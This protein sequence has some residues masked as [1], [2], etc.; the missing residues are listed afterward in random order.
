MRGADKNKLAVDLKRYAK[1][2]KIPGGLL[3][4]C[5]VLEG[6]MLNKDVTHAQMRRYIKNPR[7]LLLDC[8]LEYKKGESATNMEMSEAN[9]MV[10]ALQQEVN[11]VAQM[12]N[13]IMK[14]TPD[15]VVTEKGVSDLAQHF[16]MK[17]NISVIR[18]ARKTDN[19][20]ISRVTGATICNR[21]EELQESDIGTLCGLYEVK[22][23]GDDFFSYFVDCKEPKACTILLRG[24]SKDT[25]NELER[26]LHDAMA[27]AKNVVNSPVLLPGGGAIEMEVAQRLVDFSKTQEG[28]HQLPIKAVARAMEIIPRTLAQNCGGDT[29]RL[30]T[31]LRA[32]H[33]LGDGLYYGIDGNKG[34][35]YI[36]IFIYLYIN[37]Y[38]NI[39]INI[40]IYLLMYY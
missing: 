32:K 36:Y 20:R 17:Q 34:N 12:C 35:H 18:R 3:D 26:N 33:A 15:V 40:L 27:V 11:E 29:V 5:C 2:E 13:Y 6:V 31:D 24:G 9:H 21:P 19:N 14:W 22:K 28:M 37:I 23:I 4:D 38:I 25:L 7:V 39:N 30:I 10:D 1:V 8:N 16:L